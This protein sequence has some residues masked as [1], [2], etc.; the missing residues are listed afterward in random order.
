MPDIVLTEAEQTVLRGLLTRTGS[1][2]CPADD[3]GVVELL[4]RFGLTADDLARIR[5]LHQVLRI[6]GHRSAAGSSDRLTPGERRVLELVR[7][8]L[9]NEQIAASL[10]LAP[11]TVRKHL[12]NAFRKLGVHNRLAAVVALER[13]TAAELRDPA[14]SPA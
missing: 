6:V 14:Y 2:T 7:E 1:P 5:V 4:R 10:V 8:G 13:S 9:S 3:D 12:E 11:G